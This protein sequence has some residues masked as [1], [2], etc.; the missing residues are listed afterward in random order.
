M[1]VLIHVTRVQSGVPTVRCLPFERIVCEWE[2]RSG[3]LAHFCYLCAYGIHLVI[4]YVEGVFGLRVQPPIER[5]VGDNQLYK[6]R[7]RHATRDETTC[8]VHRSHQ[9][10]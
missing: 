8:E 3:T 6:Q 1:S 2:I 7:R 9:M 10:D 5:I 4:A